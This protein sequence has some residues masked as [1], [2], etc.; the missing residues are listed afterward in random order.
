[1]N[2]VLS[3]LIGH[4]NSIEIVFSFVFWFGN[5]WF[6]HYTSSSFFRSGFVSNIHA[7]VL[8]MVGL[9][10]LSATLNGS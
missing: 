8:A 3:D 1:M 4:N 10:F 5:D 9:A 2:Y 7:I 6:G